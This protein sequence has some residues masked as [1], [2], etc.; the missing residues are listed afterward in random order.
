MRSCGRGLRRQLVISQRI[1]TKT[2]KIAILTVNDYNIQDKMAA[3]YTRVK[4][5]LSKTDGG[6]DGMSD[7]GPGADSAWMTT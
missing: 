7:G 3:E 1:E 4:S 2:L 6:G 5:A